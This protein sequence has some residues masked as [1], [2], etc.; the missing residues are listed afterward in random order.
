MEF[1]LRV[2]LVF[3]VLVFVFVIGSLF[4]FEFSWWLERRR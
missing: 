2:V 4:Y 3:F 1:V